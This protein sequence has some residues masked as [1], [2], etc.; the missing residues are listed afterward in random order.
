MKTLGMIGGTSWHSTIEYYRLI[1]SMINQRL[2]EDVNPPLLLY[3]INIQLM[4]HGSRSEIQ[5]G[6]LKY[7]STLEKA[8]AEA[9]IFC[10]NTPHL[11]YDHVASRISIPILHIADATGDQILQ[12]QYSTAGLL[13]TKATMTR[14][15]IKR[16]LNETHGLDILVPE[17]EESIDR[18]HGIIANELTLGQ[19]TSASKDYFLGEIDL[20]RER[21]AEGVILGCTELPLLIK[22]EDSSVPLY[23]TTYLHAEKAVQFIL[24][25]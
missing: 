21:G 8:G 4:K 24:G 14:D 17:S 22:E 3:S 9:I 6:F 10:A 5:E 18:V 15:F 11:A 1:N 25:N 16:R 23:D 2:G 19:F 20:L 12:N 13:G 7:A